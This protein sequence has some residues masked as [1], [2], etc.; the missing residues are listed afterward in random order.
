MSSPRELANKQNP[1]TRTRDGF[2]PKKRIALISGAADGL[3]YAT[4][5]VY[6]KEGFEVIVTDIYSEFHLKELQMSFLHT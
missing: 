2:G 4:A 3:G 1:T 6:A 5:K